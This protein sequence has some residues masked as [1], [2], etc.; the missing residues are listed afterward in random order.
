[1]S[2]VTM[3]MTSEPGSRVASPPAPHPDDG[4]ALRPPDRQLGVRDRHRRHPLRAGQLVVGH[5]PVVGPH[6]GRPVTDPGDCPDQLSRRAQR[7]QRAVAR[8]V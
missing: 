1:M 3:S 5:V 4:P 6:V 2:S 7:V 8:A